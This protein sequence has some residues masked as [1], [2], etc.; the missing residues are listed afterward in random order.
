MVL[1]LLLRKFHLYQQ[2][3]YLRR[4]KKFQILGQMVRRKQ[5][6]LILKLYDLKKRDKGPPDLVSMNQQSQSTYC[7]VNKKQFLELWLSVTVYYK[8]I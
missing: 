6:Y 8:G 7:R 1:L 5:L 3:L 2:S 4:D